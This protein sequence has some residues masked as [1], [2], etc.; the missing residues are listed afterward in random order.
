MAVW[1]ARIID[2]DAADDLGRHTEEVGSILPADVALIHQSQKGLVNQS[3]TLEGVIRPFPSKIAA[4][5]S[6]QFRIDQR[7]KLLERLLI[8]VAPAHEQPRHVMW[9]GGHKKIRVK[10][11]I[12]QNSAVG[13]KRSLN[14]N[15]LRASWA[16]RTSLAN[17]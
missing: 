8:A 15:I 10:T 17:R 9:R 2:Q 1:R 11:I 13:G 7:R 14:R 6:P 4:G 12:S 3:R 5:Q 16:A